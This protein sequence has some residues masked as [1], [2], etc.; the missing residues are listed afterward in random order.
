MTRKNWIFWTQTK[1]LP[2]SGF[3]SISV[4]QPDYEKFKE[5]YAKLKEMG[6]VP[7]GIRSFSGYVEYKVCQYIKEKDSLNKLA[8]KI[9]TD[10]VPGKIP[11]DKNNNQHQ[12]FQSGKKFYA[13]AKES[14]YVRT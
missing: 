1:K 7:D 12:Y 5:H 9:N 13:I 10:L 8:E 6:M 14:T 3:K 2:K 4:K 11:D